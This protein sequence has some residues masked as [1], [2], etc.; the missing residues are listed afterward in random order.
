M[1]VLPGLLA[2]DSGSLAQVVAGGA[3]APASH[4]VKSGLRVVVNTSPEPAS[5]LVVSTG[6]DIA[7]AAP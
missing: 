3:G 4:L 6:E 7:V 1:D 2:G 5:H